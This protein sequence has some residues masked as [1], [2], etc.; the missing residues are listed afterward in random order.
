MPS[1]FRKKWFGRHLTLFVEGDSECVSGRSRR[2]MRRSPAWK[3]RV[4]CRQSWIALKIRSL[5]ADKRKRRPGATGSP[6]R[7]WRA[8]LANPHRSDFLNV[9]STLRSCADHAARDLVSYI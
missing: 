9:V 3:L 6:F 4:T 5:I 2:L 1:R 8:E 7:F